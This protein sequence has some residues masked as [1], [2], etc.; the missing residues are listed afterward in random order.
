MRDR[1]L[2]DAFIREKG[3]RKIPR[4]VTVMTMF[5]ELT[6]EERRQVNI[7]SALATIK[8]DIKE[9]YPLTTEG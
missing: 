6:D 3:V 7:R 2:I 1:E 8:A 4:G 5:D 9:R